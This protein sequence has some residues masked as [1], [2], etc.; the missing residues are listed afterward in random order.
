MNIKPCPF[1]ASRDHTVLTKG[2]TGYAVMCLTC[3]ANGPIMSSGDP[4]GMSDHRLGLRE[5]PAR[6]A[7]NQRRRKM[8]DED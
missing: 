7:W 2:T 3:N 5:Y 8:K 1:C 6:A 4:Y